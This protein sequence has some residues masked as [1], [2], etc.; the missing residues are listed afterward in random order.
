[1]WAFHTVEQLRQI[2]KARRKSFF[3]LFKYAKSFKSIQSSVTID[4][5]TNSI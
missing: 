1:M 2:D 5:K 3:F 4:A